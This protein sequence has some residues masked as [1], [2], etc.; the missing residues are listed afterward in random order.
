[1]TRIVP[2]ANMMP[3]HLGDQRQ[4]RAGPGFSLILRNAIAAALSVDANADGEAG[5]ATGLPSEENETGGAAF[6]KRGAPA[7][8]RVDLVKM[9][10][11][12]TARDTP[13]RGSTTDPQAGGAPSEDGTP[14][15]GRPTRLVNEALVAT[16]VDVARH[17]GRPAEGDA[18]VRPTVPTAERNGTRQEAAARTAE[19][20]PAERTA[21][22]AAQP[23]RPQVAQQGETVAPP[24][25]AFEANARFS[26]RAESANQSR[27]AAGGE[28]RSAARVPVT[29]DIPGAAEQT[30]DLKPR[31]TVATRQRLGSHEHVPA[32]P[33]E[34]RPARPD[35]GTRFAIES[36]TRAKPTRSGSA[37]DASI[38]NVAPISVD[39]LQQGTRRRT[40]P[41]RGA[42]PSAAS[43]AL[44]TKVTRRETHFAPVLMP[45]RSAAASAQTSAPAGPVPSAEQTPVTPDPRA[46]TEQLGRFL[47]STLPELKS[48]DGRTP[49]LQQLVNE[50]SVR[51]LAAQRAGPVRVVELQLQPAALGTLTVTMRLSSSG[52]KVNVSASLRE[53][54]TRLSE[55]RAELTQ[56]IRRAGYEASEITVEAASPSQGFSGG[57]DS[58]SRDERPDRGERRERQPEPPLRGRRTI[59][60]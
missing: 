22:R 58:P 60:V 37:R 47:E 52:L 2:E 56:L 25:A 34:R 31:R 29:R 11:T 26:T 7:S 40:A 19:R 55:D 6:A 36:E 15:G 42:E 35:G 33:G 18:P 32:Q 10:A 50:G 1:M 24:R 8:T 53:T 3:A 46:A 57:E 14:E 43:D 28:A 49:Q 48:A 54:A 12:S 59:H 30:S 20:A 13:A 16:F 27:F 9:L 17:T 23:V 45:Q 41:L 44:A 38:A 21:E 39:D 5:G 4:M 51:A